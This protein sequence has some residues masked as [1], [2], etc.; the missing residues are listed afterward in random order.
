MTTTDI[1]VLQEEEGL[2]AELLTPRSTHQRKSCRSQRL[3]RILRLRAEAKP[4][5]GNMGLF[6]C[7]FL[8]LL[9]N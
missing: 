5:S 8:A 7:R 3:A 1:A 6:L 2:L 4:W 9:R